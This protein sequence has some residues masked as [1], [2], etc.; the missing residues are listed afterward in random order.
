MVGS[1][2]GMSIRTSRARCPKNRSRTS[3]QAMAVPMNTL[4]TVTSAAVPTVRRIA[5][6]V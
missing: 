3:T 2:K 6:A 5:A 4:T 1:A